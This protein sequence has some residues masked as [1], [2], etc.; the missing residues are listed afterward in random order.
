MSATKRFG[1]KLRVGVSSEQATWVRAQ[2]NQ[3][4]MSEAAVIRELIE[5]ERRKEASRDL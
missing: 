2:A 5:A 3:R 1:T 4:L